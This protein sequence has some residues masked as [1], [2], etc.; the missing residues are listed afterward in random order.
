MK[1]ILGKESENFKSA[2]AAENTTLSELFPL[3]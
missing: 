2:G 3:R 1:R